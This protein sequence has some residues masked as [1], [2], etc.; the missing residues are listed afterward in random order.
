MVIDCCKR[1]NNMVKDMALLPDQDQIHMDIARAKYHSTI[2][3][4]NTYEQ[5]WIEP[6]DIWTTAFSM[7]YGTYISQVMQ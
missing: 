3:L 6:K 7:I 4:S 2:D 1:N 5:V